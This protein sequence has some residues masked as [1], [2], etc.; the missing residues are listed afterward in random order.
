MARISEFT[1]KQKKSFDRALKRAV[2]RA[3]VDEDTKLPL[4]IR[5][6][7]SQLYNGKSVY[8]ALFK[9]VIFLR[10]TDLH[11]D[12]MRIPKNTP[13]SNDYRKYEGWCYS[14]QSYL[15]NRVGCKRQYA[16]E[17]LNQIEED[18]FLRSRKYRGKTGAGTNN[19]SRW[20]M[21]SSPR[22][23]NWVRP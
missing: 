21:P 18:G 5:V 16:N 10:M 8:K 3:G 15:A 13:W 12:D 23:K 6:A 20:T 17:V 22:S 4:Y 11:E 1:D 2:A 7:E 14:R 19:I 9:E